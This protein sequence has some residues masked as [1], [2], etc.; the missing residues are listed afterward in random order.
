VK[1]DPTLLDDIAKRLAA[2]L[3]DSLQQAKADLERNFRA[4]LESALSRLD[5][6]SREEF[7][8]QTAVLKRTR[9]KLDALAAEVEQLEK[10]RSGGTDKP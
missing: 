10:E 2:N 7:D 1:P 3:P 4:V 5:L 9:E 8:T 6:V